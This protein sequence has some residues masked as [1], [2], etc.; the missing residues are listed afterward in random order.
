MR[1]GMAAASGDVCLFT[2]ADVPFQFESIEHFF[3]TL[4]YGEY[5]MAIGDR[6]LQGSSYFSSVPFHRR[7]ASAL[8]RMVLGR[9]ISRSFPDSQC[10][11]KAFRGSVARELFPQL[12][13]RGFAFDVEILFFALAWGL[14]VKR[15]PVRFRQSGETSVRLLFH[16]P[17]MLRDIV[18]LRARRIVRKP[19]VGAAADEPAVLNAAGASPRSGRA[20]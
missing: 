3:E 1:R 18:R 8:W 5:E 12:S 20:A 2:D 6:T 11:L 19:F 15:L 10:G 13:V 4:R 7:I 14:S 16:G 17:E 9:R